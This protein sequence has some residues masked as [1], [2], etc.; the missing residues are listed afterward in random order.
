MKEWEL[1]VSQG[2]LQEMHV[3]RWTLEEQ[4]RVGRAAKLVGISARPMKRL[5]R[6]MKEQGVKGCYMA[7]A[8]SQRGP[9]N[10]EI[11]GS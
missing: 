8:A 2:D 4:Q 10:L 11:L 7:T 1:K 3:V 9:K 5:Q 6:K